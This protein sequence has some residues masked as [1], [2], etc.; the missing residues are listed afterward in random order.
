M[1]TFRTIVSLDHQNRQDHTA[2][3]MCVTWDPSI[4]LVPMP[5]QTTKNAYFLVLSRVASV[6]FKIPAVYG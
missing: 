2:Y 5:S 4:F 3:P 6:A 1:K